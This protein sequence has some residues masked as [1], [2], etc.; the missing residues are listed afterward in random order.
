MNASLHEALDD[1]AGSSP[2]VDPDSVRARGDQMRAASRRRRLLSAGAVVA[3]LVV[4][5]GL[6]VRPRD[7]RVDVGPTGPA[8]TTRTSTTTSSTTLTSDTSPAPGVL[9]GSTGLVILGDDGLGGAVAVD[10]DHRRVVRRSIAGSAAGDQPH[11][12][13]LIDGT[14]ITGWG[15][16]W[17]IDVNTATSHKITDGTIYLPGTDGTI[18]IAN[19]SEGRIGAGTPSYAKVDLDGTTIDRV[20]NPKAFPPRDSRGTPYFSPSWGLGPYLL[21]DSDHGIAAW[22]PR[23]DSLAWHTNPD[24]PSGRVL[25]AR[26]GHAEGG[27]HQNGSGRSQR[28]GEQLDAALEQDR[29]MNFVYGHNAGLV[30]GA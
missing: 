10:L 30:P 12:F 25:D 6:V 7:Q 18:W 5:A 19:W 24:G 14:L 29:G 4:I 9:D 27:V 11:R 20:T 23:T 16:I 13:D 1:L 8:S 21:F 26:A 17:G 28:R 15:E 3:I 22:N 2:G